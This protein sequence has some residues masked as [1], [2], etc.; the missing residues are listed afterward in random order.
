V[1]AA[2]GEMMLTDIHALSIHA[3]TP[4]EAATG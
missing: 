1:Y 3:Q 4:H 2:L